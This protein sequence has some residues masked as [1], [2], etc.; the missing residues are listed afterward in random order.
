M[1]FRLRPEKRPYGV[2]WEKAIAASTARG[3]T[4]ATSCKGLLL[5]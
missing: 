1:L 4:Q 3:T 2:N 5:D